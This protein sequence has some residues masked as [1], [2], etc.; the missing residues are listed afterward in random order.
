MK[1]ALST[2]FLFGLVLWTSSIGFSASEP[3]TLPTKVSWSK[4]I[5]FG[6]SLTELSFTEDGQWGTLLGDRLRRVADVLNRGFGGFTSRQC[7]AMLPQLFPETMSFD[8]VAALTILLGTNDCF[9]EA[10]GVRV[11]LPEYMT[12][13]ADIVQFFVDRGLPKDKIVLLTPP[14]L[15]HEK[16]YSVFSRSEHAGLNMTFD[17]QGWSNDAAKYAAAC[18]EVGQVLQMDTLNVYELLTRDLREDAISED[19]IHFSALGSKLIFEHLWPLLEPK[20]LKHVGADKLVPNFS[21][22][23]RM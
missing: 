23:P 8:D 4:V 17:L 18:V 22:F 19:G 11:P 3:E 10:Q 20:V 2:I 5:L 9:P 16:V 12:N 15:Y 6:D 7:K 21:D 13:L 1:M 14:P